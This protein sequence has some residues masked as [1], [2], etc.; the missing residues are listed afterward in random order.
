SQLNLDISPSQVVW[1]RVVLIIGLSM[2]FAPLNVAAFRY[3]PHHLRAAAVGL[4]ALLRNEGGSVGPS[5]A[6]TVQQRRLQFH[7]ARL[8]DSLDPL[9]PQVNSFLEGSHQLF[10]EQ[11]GD[12]ALAQQMSL[13]LLDNLRQQQAASLAYF[14]V[15]W[16]CAALGVGL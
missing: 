1:P 8:D 4:F 5:V 16:L 3:V 11:T 9:N 7:L 12:T 6:Q 14:D 2:T 13:Q 10:V 15:F